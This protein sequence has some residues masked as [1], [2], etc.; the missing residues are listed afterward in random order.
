MAEST[1]IPWPLSANPG[2]R[3]GEG[4]GDLV[5]TF[6]SKVGDDVIIRR[7][8][9]MQTALQ[10]AQMTPR[11]I[12]AMPEYL[13]HAWD[14]KVFIM[15]P[16]GTSEDVTAGPELSSP[17]NPVTIASN[18]R[19]DDPQVVIVTD[20]QVLI[21]DPGT[22]EPPVLS[23]LV[24]HTLANPAIE[25]ATSVEYFSGYFFFTMPN[26]AF[27]ASGL[28]NAAVDPQSYA[29]AE[30]ASDKLLRTI[31][32]GATLLVMGEKSTEVW[33]DVGS[34]P[35][36][37]QRQTAVDVGLMG[38]WCVAG[39]ANQ[40]E[41]GVIFV[42][43]DYTVRSM[44]GYAAKVVSNDAVSA[45][46]YDYRTSPDSLVATV[47]G[48]GQWSVFSLSSPTWTWE[49]VFNTGQW[50]RRRSHLM[51]RWRGRFGA[52]WRDDWYIQAEPKAGATGGG[53]LNRM[54]FEVYT[55]NDSP[56][57][58]LVESRAIKEFPANL[59]IPEVSIDA[60]VGVSSH[61][62]ALPVAALSW[63]HDGGASWSNPLFRR[64]G[65]E[66]EFS[67]KLTVRNLGRSTHHGVRLRLVVDQPAPLVLMGGLVPRVSPSRPRGV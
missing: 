24:D 62:E 35:F 58:A 45:D 14:D 30:Y 5:N 42:A 65:L 32:N 34:S 53:Q 11:G 66:G 20:T 41:F 15:Y 38:K 49:Y 39:G 37:L 9:G 17:Y 26:S 8:G 59:R 3:P 54:L 6:A 2:R 27:F 7:V 16:D 18:L 46:I 57:V 50:H 12:H 1:A 28:Q 67:R 40:W 60:A 23:N 13:V 10:M 55:E 52:R 4:Q 19:P 64:M 33:T 61:Q 25:G 47:Y 48:F 22:L 36:P 29:V 43:G 63:S 44:E 31:N 21:L 56:M 51:D